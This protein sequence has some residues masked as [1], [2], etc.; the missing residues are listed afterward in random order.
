MI[1]EV[2]NIAPNPCAAAV[3]T[4][5]SIGST[6][7]SRSYSVRRN[8]LRSGDTGQ[9]RPPAANDYGRTFRTPQKR[10]PRRSTALTDAELLAVVSAWE[11]AA[12]LGIPFDR[13]GL[14]VTIRWADTRWA[15][16][17]PAEA[18]SRF[19]KRLREGL[20]R[21]AGRRL[22]LVYIAV[23]EQ[24]D[25]AG[26]HSHILLHIDGVPADV[27]LLDVMLPHYAG[28]TTATAVKA[29][30]VRDRGALIYAV[31]GC[32]RA[33]L[34]ELLDPLTDEEQAIL[35]SRSDQQGEIWGNR[36]NIS[37]RLEQPRPV[38]M[39]QKPAAWALDAA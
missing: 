16:L 31:K 11:V 22:D 14:W 12:E 17:T 8:P 4:A 3:S 38:D 10:R 26:I 7:A 1:V 23:H 35:R 2:S 6:T 21:R 20:S 13:G 27:P 32:C 24:S 28:A 25:T 39:R 33:Y 5:T 30:P 34:E 36:I 18:T 19:M 9:S 15:R 29:E 37:D